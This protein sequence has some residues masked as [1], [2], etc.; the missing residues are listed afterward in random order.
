MRRHCVRK[1]AR[2]GESR[3][4]AM[5]HD[6]S[7]HVLH[8]QA[9]L[10]TQ[11]SVNLAGIELNVGIKRFFWERLDQITD[12]RRQLG[13]ALRSLGAS[14]PLLF[15]HRIKRV[16]RASG[17]TNGCPEAM[18]RGT[19]K[20]RRQSSLFPTAVSN[21][22]LERLEQLTD[23]RKHWEVAPRRLGGSRL[24]LPTAVSNGFS[25]RLERLVCILK[26]CQKL[27]GG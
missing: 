2:I 6:A 18:G 27:A 8:V 5:N 25:E 17:T 24:L 12:A 16:F 22:F 23:A 14:P 3:E 11:A 4:C 21:G 20:T 10:F 1:R 13:E 19:S 9:C 7:I 26:G 15:Y